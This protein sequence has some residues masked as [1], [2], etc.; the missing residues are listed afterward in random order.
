MLGENNDD[1]K[2]VDLPDNFVHKFGIELLTKGGI[3]KDF[4]RRD[5]MHVR[6]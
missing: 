5:M 3:I 6:R 2:W 4:L 1:I